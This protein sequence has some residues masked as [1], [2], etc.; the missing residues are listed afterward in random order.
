MLLCPIVMLNRKFDHPPFH[1][2]RGLSPC[3]LG[4]LAKMD[5]ERPDFPKITL[6]L[7]YQY[8]LQEYFNGL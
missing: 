1:L 8:V 7:L 6:V 5:A 4:G 3:A 2:D